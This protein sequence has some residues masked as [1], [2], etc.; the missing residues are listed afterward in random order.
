MI[1]Q[2][3]ANARSIQAFTI[4][5]DEL[6]VILLVDGTGQRTIPRQTWVGHSPSWR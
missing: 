2:V 1:A 3:E 5:L 6:V 4:S